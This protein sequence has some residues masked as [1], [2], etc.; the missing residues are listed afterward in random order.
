MMDN[1]V[2][3]F[4]APSLILQ[5]MLDGVLIGAIFALVAYGLALVWGVMNLINIAQGEFVMLGGFVAY[6]VSLAGFS[7]LYGIPIAAVILFVVG[8][9][10]YKAVVFRIVERDFFVSIL[11]TFGI[12]I[13][14][15]QLS[16]QL[17][18]ADIVTAESGM[19]SVFL[20]DNMVVVPWIKVV[21]FCAAFFVGLALYLFLKISRLGQAI[22]ATSQN[23]RAARILGVD[24]DRVFAFTF[25]LNAAICGAA[26]ALVAMT[27]FIHPYAGHAFTVR[28]FMIVILAG[29]GNLINVGLTGLG[30]GAMENY[31]GFIIG[32]E[33]Q[34]AFVFVLLVIILVWRNF[35]LAK[36]RE[37]LK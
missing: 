5:I 18:G 11:A 35:K 8:W 23:P 36:K 21:G 25:A 9:I 2:L 33:F 27:W 20:L 4:A 26:G 19:G 28:S 6:Y 29:L 22:R 12:S 17:F 31:F 30:L 14:I 32:A 24:T 3:L 13:V 10:L 16:N 15:Q 7:P 37:Y 34:N 1:V